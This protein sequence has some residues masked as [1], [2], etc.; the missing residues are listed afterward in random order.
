V[1]STERR[2]A[3]T[4]GKQTDLDEAAVADEALYEEMKFAASALQEKNV[5]TRIKML[6]RKANACSCELRPFDYSQEQFC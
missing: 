1:L 2:E 6:C 5:L 3:A 4:P